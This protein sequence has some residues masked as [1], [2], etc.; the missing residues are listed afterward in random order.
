L[1]GYVL[2]SRLAYTFTGKKLLADHLDLI[3]F[4]GALLLPVAREVG[5]AE[6]V[7]AAGRKM[8]DDNKRFFIGCPLPIG[9][10]PDK[11]LSFYELARK[12]WGISAIKVHPNLAGI[13]LFK[14]S[15]RELI[16]AT[17]VAA[18]KLGLPVVIH[19][20]RTPGLEPCEMRE[21]GT[22][23]RLKEINWGLSSAP[24]IFAH[25]G[26]Y[27]LIESEVSTTLPVLN[28]LFDTYP[29][30]FADTSNLE[31]PALRLILE[32]TDRNRLIFGS[33]AFYV[34]IW[35]AWLGFLEALCQVSHQL[36]DDLIQ[37]TSLNAQHCL[38]LKPENAIQPIC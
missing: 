19:G 3:G 29:N 31:V 21:L 5:V 35:K 36:E 7:L 27:G 18:G 2:A 4:A 34:P 10:A 25:C 22:I 13:D 15:D 26:C 17:L 9:V 38:G 33:D 12:Q 24:V 14:K 28:H 16:E 11:S 8:F 23:H 30:L 1:Q 6:R 32:Q 37:I 20:G